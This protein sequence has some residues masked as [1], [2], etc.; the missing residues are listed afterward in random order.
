M[1]GVSLGLAHEFEVTLR[2]AGAN[3]ENFWIPL[4]QEPQLA[5]AIVQVIGNTVKC[6]I[7]QRK[8]YISLDNFCPNCHHQ[9]ACSECYAP[10]NEE[11][12]LHCS[13]CEGS[14]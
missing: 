1:S 11:G 9:L 2:K 13:N 6:A 4:S 12:G 10:M 5:K 14:V 7:C 8:C 3:P